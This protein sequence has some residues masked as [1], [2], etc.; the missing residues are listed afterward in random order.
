MPTSL[1]AAGS[2]RLAGMSLPGNALRWPPVTLEG[3]KIVA[4]SPLKSPVD[5]IARC[6]RVGMVETR[7][8]G[9]RSRIP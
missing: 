5:S 7:V 6:A 9:S 3:S 8:C 4:A 1:T 2:S